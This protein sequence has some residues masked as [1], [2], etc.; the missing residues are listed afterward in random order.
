MI[1]II[2]GPKRSRTA[3]LLR[4]KRNLLQ[5]KGAAVV[6]DPKGEL[7]EAT[8]RWRHENVGPVYA[9][10]PFNLPVKHFEG[11][12]VAQTANNT[13]AFNPLDRVTDNLS[14]NK[15]AEMVFPRNPDERQAFF[16]S[17]A[18]GFLTGVIE[19][20]G[21]VRQGRTAQRRAHQG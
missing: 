17:E 1:E 6:L 5:Y 13:H 12:P 20:L 8:A 15:L 3:D 16:D 19:F 4:A 21:A 2:G 18:I 14:A 10:N 9:L 7:Y 11:S